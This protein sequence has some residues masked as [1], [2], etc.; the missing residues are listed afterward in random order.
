MKN[1]FTKKVYLLMVFLLIWINISGCSHSEESIV[2]SNQPLTLEEKIEDFEYMYNL[3]KDNYPFF[4]V[5]K[6]LNGIDWLAN[7]D[8]YVERIKTTNTDEEFIDEMTK[9]VAELNN[10]HTHV[11]SKDWFKWVYSVYTNPKAMRTRNKPWA[12][13]VSDKRVLHRYNFDKSMAEETGKAGYLGNK[14][15]VFETA[16]IKPNKVAY[17]RIK[18]MDSNRVEED[19]KEIRKFYEKVKDYEKLIIDIRGNSG[20]DDMYW[21]ANVISPLTKKPIT[22]DNYIFTRGDYGKPFYKARNIKLK[23]IDDLDESILEQMPKDIKKNFDYYW[24]SSRTIPPVDPIDFNGKIYLLVDKIVYSASEAFAA[25]CKE[26]GFA[27]LVGET[28]G[29]DGI[30][31][32]PLLF[33]L[34]NSGLVIRFSSTLGLNGDFTINEEVKTVPDV[35]VLA[36]RNPMDN[37]KYD[38]A[39]QYVINDKTH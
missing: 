31:I 39:V 16:I 32:E 25:F 22:V 11:I 10:G 29:G 28:T 19:G 26:S 13:V 7:K 9:I 4:E 33:Y 34:P 12:K 23:S 5:N 21:M 20:G 36:I 15:P 24:I 37:F 6:R 3:L 17:L 30:G 38:L 18:T 1:T 8:E 35:E 27:T 14:E 2:I